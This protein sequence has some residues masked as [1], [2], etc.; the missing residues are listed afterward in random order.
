MHE[1]RLSMLEPKVS[2]SMLTLATYSFAALEGIIP[3]K[4][5]ADISKFQHV[6]PFVFLIDFA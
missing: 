5:K 6:D 2:L 4:I 3:I 1:L